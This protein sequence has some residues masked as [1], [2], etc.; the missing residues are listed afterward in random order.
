MTPATEVSS[1]R[2]AGRMEEALVLARQSF[3][4]TP[5]DAYLQ[6]AFGWLIYDLVK[7]EVQAF[8]V[9]DVSPGRVANHF[10]D[11]LGDYQ[12]LN[13]VERP[14]RLHS[15]LLSQVLKGS[16]AWP[17]FL[18]FAR[19]WDPAALS[20]EDT[21]PYQMPDGKQLPSL[22]MRLLYAIGRAAATDTSN[23]DDTLHAW[24]EE[25]VDH[26]LAV[27]PNDQWLRYYKSQMLIKRD[28]TDE[29][30]ECMLPVVKRQQRASWAWRLLGQTFE[31]DEPGKAI[32]C[33]FYSV[34]LAGQPSEVLNTRVRLAH[35]LAQANRFPEAA[36]Q[37]YT[38]LQVREE[39]GYKIPEDLARLARADWYRRIA[40]DKL[41]PEPHVT[42][43]AEVILFGGEAGKVETRLGVIDNQNP[44]KMLAHIAFSPIEG[45]VLNYRSFK[46]VAE[47]KVGA[48]VE[49]ALAGSPARPLRVK[50]SEEHRIPGFCEEFAGKLTLRA[51]QLFGFMQA[52]GGERI[53]VPPHVLPPSRL[54][55]DGNFKCRAI[56]APNKKKGEFG[57]KALVVVPAREVK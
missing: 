30:R 45:T 10:E 20:E 14:G 50:H 31:G 16:R 44:N 36:R 3:S 6:Q 41:P 2:K 8:E 51:G 39:L 55:S 24:A 11:W 9:G 54:I 7:R 23:G 19:W 52:T 32:T 1:L 33:C 38:A 40:K 48:V 29:A 43:A 13:H 22:E 42:E 17:G 18:R 25:M 49:V 35:L 26:G 47:F 27:H 12:R 34:Q 21:K 46:R 28:R 53:F 37:V 56:M 15:L 4:S 5:N 57:W